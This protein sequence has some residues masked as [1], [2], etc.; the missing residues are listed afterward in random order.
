[1]ENQMRNFQYVSFFKLYNCQLHI[2]IYLYYIILYNLQFDEP[3]GIAISSEKDLL[4]VADTNHH[5]VKVID[6]KKENIT[7][8]NY[9]AFYSTDIDGKIE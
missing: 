9:R 8:V 2:F 3:S 1:M 6:T 7:T 5:V 4:Y